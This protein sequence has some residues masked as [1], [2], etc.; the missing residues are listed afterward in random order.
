MVRSV[1]STIYGIFLQGI[2][3]GGKKYF[4]IRARLRRREASAI[5]TGTII[6]IIIKF[7]NCNWVFTRWQL[8]FYT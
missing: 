5:V 1:I 6:I 3:P 2:F 8:L 7:I 4:Y